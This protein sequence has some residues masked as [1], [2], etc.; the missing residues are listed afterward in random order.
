MGW[1]PAVMA[2]SVAAAVTNS[3]SSI[4]GSLL[5]SGLRE[6]RVITALPACIARY[7]LWTTPSRLLVT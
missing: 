7:R 3:S 5:A 2:R 1:P 6:P 4:S